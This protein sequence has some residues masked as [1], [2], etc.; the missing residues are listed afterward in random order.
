M[1][2]A[3]HKLSSFIC[4][5]GLVFSLACLSTACSGSADQ[6]G[7]SFFDEE[8]NPI[9]VGGSS[10]FDPSIGTPLP[11]DENTETPTTECEKTG[12]IDVNPHNINFGLN[13][14]GTVECQ[15]LSVTPSCLSH[16]QFLNF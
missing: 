10:E 6:Q 5:A 2:N 1:M 15:S 9:T 12:V 13:Q 7:P 14:L 3:I 11:P 16:I 4:R 8:N